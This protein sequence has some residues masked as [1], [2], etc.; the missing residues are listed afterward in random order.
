[1]AWDEWEHLKTEV[2]ARKSA[3]MRLNQLPPGGGGGGGGGDQDLVVRQDDLGA[4]GHEAFMLYD[5]LGGQADIA[6]AGA[7]DSGSGST[8]RAGAELK[9]HHFAMG[10][11]LENTVSVWTAQVKTVLQACA[12]ISNHLDYSAKEYAKEDEAIG[13]VLRDRSGAAVPVSR[14]NEYFT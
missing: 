11:E 1:M 8:M 5:Q 13:A 14:L 10:S 12:H 9:L 4:V 2:T 7:D 3:E 6:G